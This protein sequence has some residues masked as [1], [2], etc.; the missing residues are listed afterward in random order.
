[1]PSSSILAR[2]CLTSSLRPLAPTWA[3]RSV[4]I[5]PPA[6]PVLD[7]CGAARPKFHHRDT[8]AQ[9]FLICGNV[10]SSVA[11]LCLCA[12]VVKLAFYPSAPGERA[13]RHRMEP[14]GGEAREAERL[15]Q[16]ARRADDVV[17]DQLADAD[18]LVAVV[19][20]GDDVDIV[21]EA[22]EHRKA[23]GGE[24][25]DAARRLLLVEADLAL[26]ALLAEGQRRAPHMGEIVADDEVR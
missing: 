6:F 4:M 8:E 14:A 25:A 9:R 24:A 10:A 23:V 12:S 2:T 21:A 11:P 13:V 1:M 26:E 19:G 3:S 15:E 5:L 16:V 17:G 18:H 22:V 7:A 20:I